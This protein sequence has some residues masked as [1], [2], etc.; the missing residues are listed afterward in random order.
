MLYLL[1]FVLFLC[2]SLIVAS[3]FLGEYVAHRQSAKKYFNA[4]DYGTL[5]QF[6]KEFDAREWHFLDWPENT[7]LT[8]YQGSM[9][10]GGA[11]VFG[12]NAMVLG[13]MDYFKAI[14]YAYPKV[15][16]PKQ[17]NTHRTGLW[18]GKGKLRVIK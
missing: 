10:C 11:L 6:K 14:R 17:K 9:I 3:V 15:K 12:G 2:I 18:D 8:D 16:E 5:D 13:I 7:A 4:W 1:S